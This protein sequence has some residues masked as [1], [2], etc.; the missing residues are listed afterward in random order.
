ML[1]TVY[2]S[3]ERYAVAYHLYRA[4]IERGPPLS[5]AYN[6]CALALIELDQPDEAETWLRKALKLK[7][8]N[9]EAMSNL[10]V[11]SMR[12]SKPN[13]AVFW[14]DKALKCDLSL[15]ARQCAQEN[16][17]YA[18]LAL[19][20]W[21]AGW[22]G[23]ESM[24][25]RKWRPNLHPS[26]PYWDGKRGQRLLVSGEQGIGDEISFASILP[27][28]MRDNTVTL[29]C[30]TRLAPLFRRSFPDLEIHGTR[31]DK[32]PAWRGA[33]EF[34]AHCLIGSLAWHYRTADASFPGKPFLVA[35]AERR[36][37]WRC[38]LDQMSGRKV[39]IAWTGGLPSSFKSR[40]SVSLATLLPLLRTAGISWV[41]L[42][43]QDPRDEIAAL[44]AEHGIEIK[45]WARAA[46]AKDIDEVAALIA[47]LDLVI[48]VTTA[49]VD[50]A[51]ALGV[52][53]WVLVPSKPHWRY[54]M[55]GDKKVWYDSVRLFRQR[56]EWG[57]VIERIAH[58]L[59]NSDGAGRGLEGQAVQGRLESRQMV[60]HEQAPSDH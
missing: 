27:D 33:R 43:Y 57:E 41:S 51:G 3:V 59:R 16:K 58:E 29:D 5:E 15:D 2:Q 46:E 54:G 35:D 6:N 11:L 13:D 20:D 17:G 18:S 1:G 48:C 55:S 50:I 23:F 25:G 47:E 19:K 30:D 34:D 32:R 53:C 10:A 37:Q 28:T 52:P 36:Q 39:G 21:P 4:A 49:A 40:R 38:L 8:D 24:V 42:Q 7:P 31:F 12:Q 26:I 14:A 22:D 56:K 44:K 60:A 45:H 9:G